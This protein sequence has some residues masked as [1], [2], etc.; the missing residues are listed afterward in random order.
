VAAR[1]TKFGASEEEADGRC[2]GGGAG[3]RPAR[4]WW[5]PPA[6]SRADSGHRRRAAARP[7]DC[8]VALAWSRVWPTTLGTGT[9]SGPL[10]T[11]IWTVE[12]RGTWV[13]DGGFRLMML[14]AGIESLNR[15]SSC[16]TTS[17][18]PVSEALA[19]SNGW[20][21]KSGMVR[22]RRTTGHDGVDRGA[23]G[24][25]LAD[26][27]LHRWIAHRPRQ[28]RAGGKGL[29]ELLARHVQLEPAGGQRRG[30]G[31]LGLVRDVGQGVEHGP[32]GHVQ[33][34]GL[35]LGQLAVLRRLVRRRR[36]TAGRRCAGVGSRRS[37]R[38]RTP[39]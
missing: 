38:T 1:R 11:T 10:D 23:R 26:R 19:S 7:T 24:H 20:F 36:R 30:H 2:P 34:E 21:T 27:I 25:L 29:V 12:P 16:W 5:R 31:V 39:G 22:G 28:H 32:V 17:W 8:S 4:G 18:A 33:R 9:V 37:S 13:P 6:V 14:P 3:C 15:G 35:A